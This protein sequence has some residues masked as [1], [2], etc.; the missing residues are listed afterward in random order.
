MSQNGNA[1]NGRRRGSYFYLSYAH[2]P[3]LAGNLDADPDQWVRR[4]FRDLTAAVAAWPRR[5]RGSRPG[6]SIRKSHLA[7]TGRPRSRRL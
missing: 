7:R 6:F 4:F 2:S 1:R 5:I 3:P